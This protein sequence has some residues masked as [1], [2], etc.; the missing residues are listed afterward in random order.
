[1]PLL[2]TAHKGPKSQWLFTVVL[3]SFLPEA[4]WK[5]FWMRGYLNAF[6]SLESRVKG[7]KRHR[8]IK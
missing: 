7:T 8:Y 5:L 2:A 3:A 6:A 1:M 4:K